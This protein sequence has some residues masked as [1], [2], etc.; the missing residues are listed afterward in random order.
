MTISV[1]GS[2][3]ITVDGVPYRWS[4]RARPTY[5]QAICQGPLTFAVVN[6]HAPGSTLVVTLDAMRPDNWLDGPSAVVTPK[7]G[8]FNAGD[9][10]R[11]SL[12]A[13][14]AHAGAAPGFGSTVTRT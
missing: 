10:G 9:G 11:P 1:K 4:V 3:R 7:R 14:M 2:R 6:E 12:S 13:A 8:V 5:T